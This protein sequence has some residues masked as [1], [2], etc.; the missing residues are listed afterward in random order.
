MVDLAA[1]NWNRKL[2][3]HMPRLNRGSCGTA[4]KVWRGP[5]GKPLSSTRDDEGHV[6]ILHAAFNQIGETAINLGFQSMGRRRVNLTCRIAAAA[7]MALI[8]FTHGAGSVLLGFKRAAGGG[9]ASFKAPKY[10]PR[11]ASR[12]S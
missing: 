11:V 1:R 2:A 7:N 5:R 4:R 12:R 3:G 8:G 9:S 10:S 6:E